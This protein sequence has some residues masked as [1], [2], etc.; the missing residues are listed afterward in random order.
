MIHLTKRLEGI[1]RMVPEG[2]VLFDVG[3]D[4]GYIPISLLSKG[5]IPFAAV[6]D[7][8]KGP[9]AAARENAGKEGVSDRMSFTLSDGLK[10][11]DFASVP[12]AFSEAEKTL[13]ISGMGGELI[14]RILKE[15]ENLLPRFR[16]LILSP[17]SELNEFRHFLGKTGYSIQSEKL[18]LE[19]GKFYFILRVFAGEDTCRTEEDYELGPCFFDTGDE[20]HRLFLLKKTASFDRLLSTPGIP[21][22]K[23]RI[24]RKF[25]DLYGEAMKRYEMSG[26]DQTAG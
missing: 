7:V 25:R 11:L 20:V 21:E 5:H 3:C 10:N 8:R 9:L 15:G 16:T 26:T 17:Q 24:I 4:H 2:S 1:A 19:E 6:S 14:S 18:V 22:E 23:E 12:E 13:L